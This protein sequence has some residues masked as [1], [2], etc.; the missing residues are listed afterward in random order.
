[1]KLG[2]DGRVLG[3]TYATGVER[4][5]EHLYAEFQ[6]HVDVKLIKSNYVKGHWE[7]VWSQTGLLS[8]SLSSGIDVLF[9]PTPSGPIFLPRKI[10]L[11]VSVHDINFLLFP[12]LYPGAFR[13]YYAAILPAVLRRADLILCNSNYT[14]QTLVQR[15]PFVSN[16]VQTVYLG[17][18]EFYQVSGG[19]GGS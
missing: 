15:Y 1:M 8:D 7:H 11:V 3:R 5:A 6:R 12:E 2:F 10:K 18:S 9:C 14:K 19:G 16:K 17:S 13:H 4:Y